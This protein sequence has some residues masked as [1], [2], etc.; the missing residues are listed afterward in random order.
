M[1]YLIIVVLIINSIIANGK[2]MKKT[3]VIRNILRRIKRK[4][5]RNIPFSNGPTTEPR[6]SIKRESI[7]LPYGDE[8]I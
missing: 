3:E 8:Y 7:F 5:I 2:Y 6:S 4:Y 1:A